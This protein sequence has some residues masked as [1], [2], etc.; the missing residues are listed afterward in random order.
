MPSGFR[1]SFLPPFGMILD[2]EIENLYALTPYDLSSAMSSF[3][4][5]YESVATSPFVPSLIFPGTLLKTS[6]IDGPLPSLSHDPSIWYDAAMN[7]CERVE[8][9]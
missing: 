3:H 8:C 6:Q 9:G 7:G 1:G 2:H 4:R 5:R